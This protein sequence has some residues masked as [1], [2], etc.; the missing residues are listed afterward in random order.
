MESRSLLRYPTMLPERC[1]SPTV[2]ALL[3]VE[4][5]TPV[6]HGKKGRNELVC[7]F[8]ESGALCDVAL[9]W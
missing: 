6:A 8:T 2:K 1:G 5:Q 4:R 7:R 9:G 3:S